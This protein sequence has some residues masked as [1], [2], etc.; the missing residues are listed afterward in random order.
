MKILKLA[1]LFFSLLI[2]SSAYGQTY[3]FTLTVQNQTVDGTDFIFDIYMV[4]TGDTDIY[5]GDCDFVL[6]FNNG[7]FTSPTTSVVT[8]ATNLWTNYSLSPTIVSSNRIVLNVGKPTWNDQAQFDA[9][10][11]VISTSGNGTLISQ[12]K[13]TGITTPSGTAGLQWKTDDPNKTQVN[14]L[15]NTTLWDMHNINSSGTYTDPPDESLPVQMTNL[16]AV[17]S[18]EDG[19]TLSWRTESETDCAGFHVWRSLIEGAEYTCITTTM[20]PGQGNS[21]SAYDYRWND[22][23]V[24]DDV[25]YYYKIEEISIDGT[26]QFFGPVEVKG[27][28]PIP[29]EFALSRNYPNPFNPTTTFKYQL[30]EDVDLLITI[31]NLLGK[32]IKILINEPKQAGYYSSTWDGTDQYS[33][34]VSSGIYFIHM[35]AGSFNKVRKITLLR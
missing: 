15:D 23:N 21:S 28:S 9:R 24:E 32:N 29:K 26:S 5:L 2:T 1:T 18:Q 20:I 16:M 31:Y 19:I 12:I 4:R 14:R 22:R 11:Q 34:R 27:V 33:L 13:I 10:V 25:I 7:N 6:T 17:A 8:A 35:R 3:N 30:P